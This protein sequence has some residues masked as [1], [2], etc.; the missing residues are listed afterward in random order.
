MNELTT[1]IDKIK[2]DLAKIQQLSDEDI[3]IISSFVPILQLISGY[4]KVNNDSINDQAFFEGTKPIS[5]TLQEADTAFC[6][7]SNTIVIPPSMILNFFM[8]NLPGFCVYYHELGHALY[9][10]DMFGLIEKWKNISAN[11][12]PY[13][14]SSKYL[15]L[16]NWIEDFYI[17]NKIVKNYIYLTDIIKC[18]RL[19]PTTYDI[20]LPQYAFHYYY[21]T[22]GKITPAL[23]GNDAAIFEKYIND[24]LYIRA[25]PG[26]NR[27]PL[28]LLNPKNINMKYI[29]IIKE[30]YAWCVQH[31]ILADIPTPPLSLPINDVQ[32]TQQ[33]TK[34][35]KPTGNPQAIDPFGTGSYSQHSNIITKAT[36]V[37]PNI[38]QKMLDPILIKQFK[39]EQAAIAKTKTSYRA[40][41]TKNNLGGIFTTEYEDCNILTSK[42]IIPNFFNL[43]RIEDRV[44]FKRPGKTFNNVS[45]YRDISG[46]TEHGKLFALIDNVCNYLISNIPIDTHFYLYASGEI[47]IMETKYYQWGDPDDI[48]IEYKNDPTYQQMGGGTN[49]DAIADV[50]SEQ[51]NDKWLNIIVTDGDLYS[52]FRKDNIKTLLQNIA[53]IEVNCDSCDDSG[54]K[55]SISEFPDHY[56]RVRDEKDI[57]NIVDMLYNLK[58]V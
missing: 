22:Q 49:S 42:P 46:S 44:L 57:P 43:N 18:L 27:G 25:L 38:D 4:Y 2:E 23:T 15:H 20:K 55:D 24:L 36:Q 7:E 50:I 33:Q 54:C 17:E 47:S 41:L 28:S 21:K 40:E 11:F 29:K 53:V 30:F 6:T 9:S 56:I 16:V 58:E 31:K 10:R 48:P 3:E 52:L 13:A 5:I 26:F 34:N 12:V 35:G 39:S 37:F 19:I 1:N 32:Y 8:N 45:I 51:Y 14:Y